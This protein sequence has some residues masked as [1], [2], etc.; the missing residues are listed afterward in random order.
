MAL[1]SDR[2]VAITV[3]FVTSGDRLRGEPSPSVA[4]ERTA[5]ARI[6]SKFLGCR[7]SLFLGFPDGDVSRHAD[8]I[9]REI[10]ATIAG[11][12]PDLVLAPS[13]M[14][15]HADHV[16]LAHIALKLSE[17]LKKPQLV[18]Y[19]IYTTVRFNCLVDITNVIQ[20]KKEAIE[21]Y[22]TS[23]YDRP[24]VYV[25]AALGLNAHRSIFTQ[26]KGYFEAFYIVGQ[27]SPHQNV[28]DY[29]AY[30]T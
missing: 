16:A 13:P 20:K 21:V 5:E 2:G 25:H 15:F 30:R 11:L 26:R 6:A 9:S 29:L 27:D 22:R 7:E 23:L 10:G 8:V 1:L 3:C 18:F 24:E 4:V 28:L 12:Q 19:E 14:D 17:E